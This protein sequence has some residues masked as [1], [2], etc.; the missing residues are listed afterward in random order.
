M[1]RRSPTKVRAHAGG[2]RPALLLG[3]RRVGPLRRS[4][5]PLQRRP[6]TVPPATIIGLVGPNGA[7]KSTLFGVLSGLLRPNTGSV[8]LAGED[9]TEASPQARARRAWPGHSSS[10]SSS[11]ASPCASIWCSPTGCVMPGPGCGRTCSRP[12]RLRRPDKERERAGRRPARSALAHAVRQ[13]AGRQ[14]AARH[15]PAGRGGPGASPAAR[16]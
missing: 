11:W 14:P 2:R 3:R 15:Q 16:R 6:S 8:F 10:P 5:G 4:A 1:T 7:G 12:G 13:P 9:V